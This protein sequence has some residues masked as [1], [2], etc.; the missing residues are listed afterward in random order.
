MPDGTLRGPP[1][2]TDRQYLIEIYGT[3]GRLCDQVDEL[4][5]VM[6]LQAGR[7]QVVENHQVAL[8]G[9]LAAVGELGKRVDVVERACLVLDRLS[10]VAISHAGRL[11]KLELWKAAT[12]SKLVMASVLSG[13][14][15]GTGVNIAMQWMAKGGTP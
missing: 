15:L 7:L 6:D 10:E 3:V 2:E 1:P 5:Q 4:G 12:V 14:L 8:S 13:T 11:E 9:L